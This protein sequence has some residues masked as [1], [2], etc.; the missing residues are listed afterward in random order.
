MDHAW[1]Y[2][3]PFGDFDNRELGGDQYEEMEVTD[4]GK[5]IGLTQDGMSGW[6]CYHETFEEYP[7][8]FDVLI[9]NRDD[10]N[11]GEDEPAAIG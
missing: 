11:P 4:E 2:A 9:Y 3:D 1:E 7:D 5:D 8:F 10:G 6:C